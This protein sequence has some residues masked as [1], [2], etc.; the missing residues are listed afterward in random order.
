MTAAVFSI[1][2]EQVI[3]A[4]DTLAMAGDTG[5]PFFFTTKFYILPHLQ[6]VMFA[7]GIGDLAS[8]WFSQL[9]RYRARDIHR[10]D[11]F[12]TPALRDLG[13]EFGLNEKLTTTVYHVGYSEQESRYVGFA[14]R[15]TDLFASERLEYGLRVKPPVEASPPQNFPDDFV[16]IMKRQ[17]EIDDQ[18]PMSERVHIG[19]EI[20]LL[21]MQEGSM[22]VQTVHRFDEYDSLYLEMCEQLSSSPAEI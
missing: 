21:L 11:D 7:T 13:N 10:L 9:E 1:S 8:K 17:K 6:G 4:M 19:G 15:S 2:P 14:Y 3:I 12:V 16:A 18:K 22:A 20:H 5:K